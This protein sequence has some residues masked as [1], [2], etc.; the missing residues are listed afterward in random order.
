M[1]VLKNY[2]M[3]RNPMRAIVSISGLVVAAIV[4]PASAQTVRPEI[5][6]ECAAKW[7]TDYEMQLYCREKQME[8][9]EKLQNSNSLLN[10][11][12]MVSMIISKDRILQKA[13][14]KISL[15]KKMEI[16]FAPIRM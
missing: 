8:A 3:E 15:F 1:L 6:Q 7:G 13:F 9:W 14:S 4:S 12:A 16:Q 10:P 11:P 2:V 5:A